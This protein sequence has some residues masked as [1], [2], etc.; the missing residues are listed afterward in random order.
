MYVTIAIVG[1]VV[2]A[3]GRKIL[4]EKLP[5]LRKENG[6]DFVVVNGEN[7]A[8]GSGI[9]AATADELFDAGAD[10][11]TSGDHIWKQKE[12]ISYIEEEERILRPANYPQAAPGRGLGIYTAD[13]EVTFAVI[14]LLGRTFMPPMDSPFDAALAMVDE[15]RKETSIIIVDFHA[16]ATSEKVAMGWL[17][18]GRTSAVVGTHT[19]IQTADERILPQGT[20][21]VTD[22]GMTGPYDSVLGRDKDK[23]LSAL[24][25]LVPISFKVANG[26]PRMCGVILKVDRASGKAVSI[27][28][29]QIGQ[30]E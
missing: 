27:E 24:T 23:V 9:T 21:Y 8:G 17:L 5:P 15:A 20:A 12:I 16:E 4:A 29:F 3:P 6:I 7:V 28:R 11:I 1:D 30:E 14:N 10:C 2:G 13:N 25:T 22:L 26:D 19:H 18:D